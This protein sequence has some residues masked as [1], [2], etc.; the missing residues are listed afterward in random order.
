MSKLSAQGLSLLGSVFYS[1]PLKPVFF[2]LYHVAPPK[3]GKQLIQ[4]L[5]LQWRNSR[6]MEGNAPLVTHSSPWIGNFALSVGKIHLW[7]TQP[8]AS[9]KFWAPW[10]W[11]GAQSIVPGPWQGLTH[12][13]SSHSTGERHVTFSR[14]FIWFGSSGE[15][16]VL[17]P[18]CHFFLSLLLLSA[19]TH[20][21]LT[22]YMLTFPT[23]PSP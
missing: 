13:Y 20:V 19:G 15:S 12:M 4:K 9:S 14:R 17:L 10:E 23:L 3:K 5:S 2:P 22:L 1:L 21:N 7:E 16:S 6:H 8:F 11:T 18:V